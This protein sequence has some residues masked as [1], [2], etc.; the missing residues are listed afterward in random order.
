MS[1]KDST[2]S[3]LKTDKPEVS[4]TKNVVEGDAVKVTSEDKKTQDE[5]PEFVRE[6]IEVNILVTIT[7]F[8][9]SKL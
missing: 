6:M 9:F 8:I 5:E 7:T 4:S 3:F 2:V 1:S